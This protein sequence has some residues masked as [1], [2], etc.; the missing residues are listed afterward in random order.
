[1]MLVSDMVLLWDPGFREHL[2]AA[3]LPLSVRM[4]ALDAA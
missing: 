4:I 3:K 1:M 2:E